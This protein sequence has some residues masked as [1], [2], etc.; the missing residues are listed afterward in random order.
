MNVTKSSETGTV[1]PADGTTTVQ[2]AD[3]TTST[4]VPVI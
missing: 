2:L 4:A 1:Q 3:D